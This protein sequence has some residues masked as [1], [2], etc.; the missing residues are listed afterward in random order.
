MPKIEE[1][2]DYDVI[3]C[4]DLILGI[5]WRF[6]VNKETIELL[7]IPQLDSFF[8]RL[9]ETIEVSLELR[10]DADQKKEC[11]HFVV[12][13]FNLYN[14]L[15]ECG[16]SVTPPKTE[17][18]KLQHYKERLIL[19]KHNIELSSFSKKELDRCGRSV[20]SLYNV[21]VRQDSQI[22]LVKLKVMRTLTSPTRF[23]FFSNIETLDEG[24]FVHEVQMGESFQENLKLSIINIVQQILSHKIWRYDI[25]F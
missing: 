2:P 20:L 25:Y 24:D 7:S 14:A 12:M 15:I 5:A 6:F 22:V 8:C 3:S 23:R 16:V 9:T 18:D 4:A 17:R 11:E 21:Y 10:D 1:L 19:Y 13:L